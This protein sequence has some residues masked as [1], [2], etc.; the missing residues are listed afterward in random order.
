MAKSKRGSDA[1]LFS[2]SG[3]SDALSRSR[4]T[5][6]RALSGIAPD[7]VRSGLKLWRMQR[8]ID[9]VNTRTQ[10]PILTTRQGG[11]LTGIDAETELA[12]QAHDAAFDAMAKLPTLAGRR[13]AARG[14]APLAKE[15]LELM[16]ERDAGAG[17]HPEHVALKGER[18]FQLIMLGVRGPCKWSQNEA[19]HCYNPPSADDEAA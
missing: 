18:V 7:A 8:I 3:A 10:A 4:R 15:A 17:L 2:I 1:N 12:F 5:I 11:V 14:L 9:A 16:R 19:W 13:R 6:T